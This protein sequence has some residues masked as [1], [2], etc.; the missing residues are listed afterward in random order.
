MDSS[1]KIP[2]LQEVYTQ[3]RKPKYLE[4]GV[5]ENLLLIWAGRQIDVNQEKDLNY[6]LRSLIKRHF[7]KICIMI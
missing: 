6:Y 7:S 4:G 3:V 1:I 2:L 5:L